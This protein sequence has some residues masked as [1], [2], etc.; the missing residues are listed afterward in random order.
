MSNFGQAYDRWLDDNNPA[1]NDYQYAFE[2]AHEHLMNHKYN[3]HY[4]DVFMEALYECDLNGCSKELAQA[5][6]EGE[7]GYE[8]LGKVVWHAVYDYLDKL[9]RH[10]A[11]KQCE[12]IKDFI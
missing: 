1:N 4:L 12:A 11:K 3:P 9:A 5:I 2:E 7:S 6:A 8:K 10:K